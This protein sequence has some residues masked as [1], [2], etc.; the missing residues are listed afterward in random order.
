[1]SPSVCPRFG[2][3]RSADREKQRIIFEP[4]ERILSS[5]CSTIIGGEG[6]G[7]SA[8]ITVLTARWSN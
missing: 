8:A 4:Q 7:I 6:E 3:E 5:Y 1:M 2:A